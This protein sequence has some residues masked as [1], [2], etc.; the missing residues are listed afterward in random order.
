MINLL[1]AFAFLQMPVKSVSANH[2][3]VYYPPGVDTSVATEY[4]STLREIYE[5]YST[6]LKF[7]QEGRLIV[8]L[9]HD[10]Y[11]FLE[12]TGKGSLFSPLWREGRLYII[13]RDDINS[14]GYRTKLET[15]VIQGI[16]SRMH[17][18]GAPEWLVYSAAVYESGE[19]KGLSPPPFESVRYFSDLAEKIQ[20]ASSQ[21]EFSDLLFYLGNTGKFLDMKFGAGSLTRLI[22][23]F[24]HMTS[25]DAAVRKAFGVSASSLE[26]DWQRYLSGLVAQ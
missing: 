17:H 9:C 14:P 19:Y 24:E 20:S 4:L 23:E 12:L 13:A 1:L 22:H 21:T 18:N 2:V 26:E 7:G 5:T 16:L 6:E 11:D 25:F 10:R 8:R 3:T 15:G